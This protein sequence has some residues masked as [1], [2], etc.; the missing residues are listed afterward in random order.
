MVRAASSWRR[1]FVE[2]REIT[3]HFTEKVSFY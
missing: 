1:L 3:L 2:G